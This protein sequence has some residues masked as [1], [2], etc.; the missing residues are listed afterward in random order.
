MFLKNEKNILVLLFGLALLAP[1]AGWADE[2]QTMDPQSPVQI[3]TAIQSQHIY[4]SDIEA[5]GSEID[6]TTTSFG[7]GSKFK[8]AGQLP[9][10]ILLNIGHKEINTDSP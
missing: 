8:V 6:I 10:E 9:V 2:A 1:S 5:T 4:S 3:N 7:L